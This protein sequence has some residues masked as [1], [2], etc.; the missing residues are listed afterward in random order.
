MFQNKISNNISIFITQNGYSFRQKNTQLG[1][2]PL[3]LRIFSISCS[4]MMPE[5]ATL[6][7]PRVRV[8]FPEALIMAICSLPPSKPR[9]DF[10]T[11]EYLLLKQSTKL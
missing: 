11:L 5:P 1:N 2:Q 8:M 3:I 9:V 4:A 10:L 7:G 6:N